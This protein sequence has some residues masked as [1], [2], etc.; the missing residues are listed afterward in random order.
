MTGRI[1][2]QFREI[3]LPLEPLPGRAAIAERTKQRRRRRVLRPDPESNG[4][5]AASRCRT[6]VPY[7]VQT[8]CFGDDMAMVFL[9]GE[10]VVDYALRLKWETD[11]E[12]TLGRRLQQRRALLHPLAPHPQRGRIRGR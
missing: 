7:V 2:C 6:T 10:V 4:S 8:W 1:A 3:E 9:A 5:T 12:P 11:A